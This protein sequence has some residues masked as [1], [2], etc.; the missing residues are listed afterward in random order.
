MT[1]PGA[2]PADTTADDERTV[3]ELRLN[4][5][6]RAAYVARRTVGA[7]VTSGPRLRCLD[8]S[9]LAGELTTT[10][11]AAGVPITLAV[12]ESPRSVRLS[13]SLDGAA[14]REPDTIV[15][16]LLDRIS[17]RWSH[18]ESSLWFELDLIRR[19]D[20]STLDESELFAMMPDDRDA[21]DELFE[22]YA[23]FAASLARR[24]RL[25]HQGG[26]DLEQVAHLGLVQAL[27]RFDPSVGAKFTSYAGRWITGVLK[28]HLRDHAWS[29]RVPRTLKEGVLELS[30]T[31]EELAQRLGRDPT[32]EELA[33][34][35]GVSMEDLHEMLLAGDTYSLAS[36]D[37]PR[38][39]ESDDSLGDSLGDDDPDLALA[40]DW[41]AI[42]QVLDRL[43]DRERQVLY[44]RFFEDLTQAEIAPIVGVSQVHV[45][46]ILSA[47]LE[48]VRDLLTS[49]DDPE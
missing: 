29:M 45:S 1:G 31:K 14:V 33:T 4:P 24:F 22:R 10:V 7:L 38:V 5:T 6:P 37:A 35:L 12:R 48:K 21:R 2:L 15:S 23:P 26:E 16:T 27:E 17:D 19:Q 47:S 20:L 3:V 39:G 18:D 30:R 13:V 25:R 42:E 43:P 46:R 34:A 11:L 49:P 9:L 41:P 32:S 36:L 28:R 44:L 8:A 40:E